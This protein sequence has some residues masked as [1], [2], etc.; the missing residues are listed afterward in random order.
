MLDFFLDIVLLPFIWSYA[1]CVRCYDTVSATKNCVRCYET[2]Q[3]LTTEHTEITEKDGELWL[4]VTQQFIAG[5][6]EN[7]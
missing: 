4:K 2:C 6:G 5:I 3:L 7:S 1:K